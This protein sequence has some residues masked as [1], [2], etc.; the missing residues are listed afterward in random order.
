MYGTKN[1]L[2]APATLSVGGSRA[3]VNV[4]YSDVILWM[5]MIFISCKDPTET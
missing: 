5:F 4:V 3:R 1:L 2:Y